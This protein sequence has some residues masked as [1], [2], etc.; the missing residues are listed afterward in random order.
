MKLWPSSEKKQ[1]RKHIEHALF[2]LKYARRMKEDQIEDSVLE[3]LRTLE[4]DLRGHLKAKRL[5]EGVALTEP[6][7][8]LAR[9]VHPCPRGAYSLR[10]N[11]EVFVVVLAV[12]LGFRTYFFQPYQIP[13]GSMQ[14]TLYGITS[15]PEVEPDWTDRIPARWGKFL[16][17]GSRHRVI[18]ARADGMMPGIR[19]WDRSDTFF[20]IRIGGARHRIHK[21]L[22]F[23]EEPSESNDF[24]ASLH[25]WFPRPGSPIRKGDVI[26]Q[27]MQKQ[28]DHIIVNRLI[29]NFREPRR[30]DIVVFTTQNL[31]LVRANSAYIK[32]LVGLPGER[33]AITDG[34][35]YADGEPILEPDVFVRQIEHPH[36]SGYANPPLESTAQY[37]IRPLFAVNSPEY[38]LGEN[39]YLMLGDN[40]HSSLDSRYF[41]GVPGENIIG[42]GFFV[43]WPFFNRGI[44]NDRAGWVR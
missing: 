17:T 43:P 26:T 16:L 14:P 8:A 22:I 2:Q 41:G 35:A 37:G 40:T 11:V 6:A 27:G 13:T 33:M 44:H 32:R 12:A 7:V 18:R 25:S 31:P 5:H 39:R 38:Q 42:I 15:V 29:T 36:Y 9:D 34:R 4:R 23:A 28:G 30:G 10:E 24:T 19:D 20:V 3:R 21:D 1:Q